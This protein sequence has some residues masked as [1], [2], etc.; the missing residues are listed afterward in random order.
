MFAMSSAEQ[1]CRD[2]AAPGQRSGPRGWQAR[3]DLSF[4]RRADKTILARQRH[5]GPL[6]VQRP[7][8]PEGDV[9]HVYVV[10][11]P[12]GMVAGDELALSAKVAPDS[13]ALLTTPAAGKFYRSVG[14]TARLV[15]EFAVQSGRLEW[16][17]QENIFYPQALA[18][19]QTYI[20]LVGS[21][22][23]LGWEVSCFGLGAQSE[24]FYS[25]Q[26]LQTLELW[27]DE[28]PLLCERQ[29]IDWEC[30]AARWGLAGNAAVGTLLAYPALPRDVE[31]AREVVLADGMI[32]STL[33]DGVMVCR[34]MAP[35]ADRLRGAFFSIW[36]TVRPFIMGRQ[37]VAPRV[38]AT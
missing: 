26:L 1:K 23:L 30:I 21:A 8:Y 27:M 28:E 10:H 4:E 36:S 12:G 5:C 37:A 19:V 24:A 38:W 6:V 16:L 15:Q 17:P 18:E 9:C 33:V 2:V 29:R 32:S 14:P 34:A 22:K 3:L 25:G 31:V 35:H 7:F 13:H 20:R 11:P